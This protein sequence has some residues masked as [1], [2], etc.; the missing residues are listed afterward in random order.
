MV[1]L[2]I[3]NVILLFDLALWMRKSLVL[4]AENAKN[5]KNLRAQLISARWNRYASVDSIAFAI[6]DINQSIALVRA[7]FSSVWPAVFHPFSTIYCVYPIPASV[8]VFGAIFLCASTPCV[9]AIAIVRT[10][11]CS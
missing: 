6:A 4:F 3:G 11:F 10:T 1:G 2:C 5:A 9:C 8:V 7:V